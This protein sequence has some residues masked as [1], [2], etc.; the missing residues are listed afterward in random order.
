[1][2]GAPIAMAYVPLAYA[3][4]GTIVTLT[5]RGKLFTGTVTPMPF[6]P[7]RYQRKGSAK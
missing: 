4:P 5:S 7:H 3:V 2:Y 1:M 6:L